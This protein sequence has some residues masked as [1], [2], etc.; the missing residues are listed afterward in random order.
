MDSGRRALG[1]SFLGVQWLCG[2]LAAILLMLTYRTSAAY[3]CTSDPNNASNMTMF[4]T[5]PT[6]LDTQFPPDR[7]GQKLL[8]WA[9]GDGSIINY[10]RTRSLEEMQANSQFPLG[11][12]VGESA[13]SKL[14]KRVKT[15]GAL[16][17]FGWGVLLPIGA[18]VARYAREYD[19]AWF[20]IHAT[21]QL[22]GFIFIIAGVATG[23]A[24]AKDVEV[25]GLNGHKG[26]GLFLLILAIL[27]VLAVVFRPKKDSNTR[28]YWNWYHWWVGRLALFLACIN[29]FV[30]LNLSNGERKLRV[31]YIV[32]LAFELVAFAILETIYWVRWNRAPANSSGV[33]WNRASTERGFQMSDY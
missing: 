24:L 9:S 31:S 10:H 28:K 14:E 1:S 29:V 11:G 2:C 33:R 18:I 22:I 17:V 23:V 8:V 3:T 27:Q 25:P 6:C 12:A 21:F 13:V 32:L 20:Y 19:P 5:Q 7:N 16:Q 26:L 30:G 15:H 4:K